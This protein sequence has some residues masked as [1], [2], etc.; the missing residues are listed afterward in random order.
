MLLRSRA[1]ACTPIELAE[2]QVTVGDERGHTARFGEH[3]RLAVADLAG[4]WVEAVGMGRDVAEQVLRM[5]SKPRLT[6]G[7]LKR[8]AGTDLRLVEPVQQQTRATQRVECPAVIRDEPR[9]RL[10]L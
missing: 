5:G 8:T 10:T 2:A 3:Q 9:R 1:F 6:R 7:R 4:L